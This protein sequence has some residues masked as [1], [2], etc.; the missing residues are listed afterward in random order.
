MRW[1]ARAHVIDVISQDMPAKGKAKAATNPK[2]KVAQEI[3]PATTQLKAFQ[4]PLPADAFAVKVTLGSVVHWDAQLTRPIMESDV[5]LKMQVF[6]QKDGWHRSYNVLG[7][8]LD[9]EERARLL[10]LIES[11]QYEDH[12]SEVE[13]QGIWC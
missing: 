10:R 12:G 5:L 9:T 4:V 1:F 7:R 3:V 6:V 11:F 13:N 8:V 2:A